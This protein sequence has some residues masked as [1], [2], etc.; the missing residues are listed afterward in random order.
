L[1]TAKVGRTGL[2]VSRLAL[3]TGFLGG[4]GESVTATRFAETVAAAW[5]AGVTYFD[6]APIYGLGVSEE[7]L[8]SALSGKPRGEYVVSSKIGRLLRSPGK[9]EE[10]AELDRS[11][12]GA[13]R[14]VPVRD[15]V[16][17]FSHDG[18]LR[19]IEE[20]LARLRL[21][22]L[23]IVYI[24]DTFEE[25]Q[26]VAAMDG[27]YRALNRLRG[28]GTIGALGVGIGRIDMLERYAR[29]G[30]FDCFLVAGRY[31]LLDHAPAASL[32][33]TCRRKSISIMLGGVFNSGILADPW[34]DRASFDYRPADAAIVERARRLHS[35]CATHGVPLK[36]AALQFPLAEPAVASVVMGASQ[37][38]EVADNVALA[39]LVIPAALWRDLA[40]AG[41]IAEGAR[42]PPA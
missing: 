31:T 12:E 33:A 1:P 37:P 3:G 8:G 22:R 23:D 36:A 25:H 29:D 24:H 40:T 13:W 41:L 10:G 32:V 16:V 2:T 27:A 5:A 17:D 19:S 9:A 28:E 15:L 30:D 38:E 11:Y 7:R 14:G 18:A 20:S 34:R 4:L 6:T 26:Y 39:S 35:I 21:S 42:V